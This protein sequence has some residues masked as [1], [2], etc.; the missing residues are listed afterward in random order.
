[1]ARA[2]FWSVVTVS[3]AVPDPVTE[4][5]FKLAV[6]CGVVPLML[7]FTVPVNP[8]IAVTVTV[9]VTLD[10]RGM[11]W[12]AGEALMENNGCANTFTKVACEGTPELLMINSR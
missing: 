1:M 4:V 3:V 7:R 11:V 12:L 8:P 10:P 9:K 5:G 2:A 6:T